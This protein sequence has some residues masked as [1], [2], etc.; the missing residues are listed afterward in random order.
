M[1]TLREG[2]SK[3]QPSSEYVVIVSLW[4]QITNHSQPER[5]SY[6]QK[7]R[8]VCTVSLAL[9]V[10]GC[11]TFGSFQCEQWA[12]GV[13][14]LRG[15]WGLLLQES[16]PLGTSPSS[17]GK[18]PHLGQNSRCLCYIPHPQ[19]TSPVA[20]LS[21]TSTATLNVGWKAMC[22]WCQNSQLALLLK[23]LR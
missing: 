9:M 13:V 1:Q 6:L 18:P 12:P 5:D 7:S 16:T 22:I 11:P 15:P 23:I 14:Y 3:N 2:N 10:Y 8:D 21:S 20:P 4:G 17:T 19:K